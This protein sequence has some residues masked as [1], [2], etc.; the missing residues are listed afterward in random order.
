MTDN[1]ARREI[2]RTWTISN[3]CKNFEQC[4]QHFSI[5]FNLYIIRI[6]LIGSKDAVFLLIN[7]GPPVIEEK[8]G[9][10][11]VSE[12]NN[13]KFICRAT[14]K[15]PPTLSWVK[16]GNTINQNSNNTVLSQDS[17]TLTITN[18]KRSDAGKYVCNAKNN[19]SSISAS[20]YL[21][22]QCK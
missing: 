14:G 20:A 11:T 16:D 10:K 2:P 8:P 6:L 17:Q 13:V 12:G 19:V 18:V 9:N 1:C 4:Q 22:V 21:D 5:N 7:P 3:K 15:P